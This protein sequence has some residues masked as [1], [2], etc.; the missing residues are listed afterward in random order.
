MKPLK[1]EVLFGSRDN[2]SP[3]LKLI[4]GS[5]NA[6]ANA[7]KNARDEVKRLN[8]QQKQVDGFVRQKKATEDSAKALKDVQER[9]KSLRQEMTTNPSDK[10]SKDFD[11]A[12]KEAKKLKDAHSQN[13][14]KLQE[15]RNELKQTGVSTSN[16]ADHQSELSR[17]ITTANASIDNQKKKLDSLNRIQKSHSNISGNV[18]TAALYGAGMTAT[19][20]AAL[21]QMRKPIDESKRVDVEENRIASLGF[22]KKATDEAVQYAKAMKTFGTSTLDNLTLVRDGVTAFGDV[23]HAQWVAPTLAK[24]KFAN[25]AMYGDHGV[26][27]EKKFMDMLKVIEMRNGLKSKESFQEQA[28]IIQQVI[29]ATGGRVQAE[30]WLNVIKTGGIAAKGMDNKAFYYKM[31]PLVQEMGGH[32]VGTSMMSAYQNL[33]QGRTTQ[34]AA[35]NLDK[36][37]LIGDYSKV[38]HNKTGDLSYLDIGAIKGAD[39][40]KKDQFAW[41][42][43]VLVPALNAKGITKESDVIDAIGSIFSNRTASNLFAQMYMQRDQIHKNAKLNEGAFNIDQL[44]TQAQGTTSGKELE[45]RAKLHDAY[46]QFG[47]TILPIYTQALIMA[48]NA[49]QGFTGW[50]QQNPTLAKALGTGLLLIA[51]GLVAIGGLLLI[52]SPLILSMLS[53]RLMMVTLGVQGSALSFVFK[54]LTS[55]FKALGSSVMWLGRMLFAAGQLMRA[56][57][58]ILAVTLLA[59]AAY[60]IYQN[61]A[62]I[63]SFFMDLWTGVKNAFNTGVSFIKGII[64]SVDQVFA[65]NPLLNLLFPLI[66]IPR[67]IIANWSG[68]TGFFSSVW[69][70]ITTG[71]ANVWNSIV[72]YLGPIG[73]WFA[74]KWENI[75]LVTSVV[76]SGIKSV[77]TT[78]WDNLISAITNSPLFQRIVDGWTKIFDYLGSLKN[79]ML[80]IGKNIIDGLVNGIQSGFD[81]LKTIWAKINSYMPDFM[82]TKMDIHSPSR[83]MAE[84]GGHVIGG[85]GMGLT[86]AF[87]ELKNKYNQVLNLFSNKA[88]SPVLEQVDIAAPVLSKIQTQAT[89]NTAPSRQT[90]LAV[91]GDTYTIHIHAAPGQVVQDIERQIENVVMRLQRDK[92]ARLRT[93]MADQE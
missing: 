38:K 73:D 33:Y 21:Y 6:A 79:K 82:R 20:A 30:E 68:I 36:F 24:M 69:T 10:I 32:R 35:A 59:T 15:L 81:S 70:S 78:A 62:P 65:D 12:T 7:L 58:I 23:H 16:L 91:A 51:G 42:E 1:L 74:A 77:V 34:R 50:M 71:V 28:N 14:A 13:Q 26:E 18:R 27:N 25:E 54:M 45:A 66:G 89:P 22:G 86:Q 3:A 48:S 39:L 31:E 92:L 67:L 55:P 8:E 87:P 93:Y 37:G 56:N 41:M 29:T 2:L 76:W 57:P 83:V 80:S 84:L 64:Q 11:K 88:Q 4:I 5:S 75:K 60:F 46:L 90:S 63:K 49:M 40:F 17:K 53:L 52:F 44:N 85:I 43:K 61:W 19:G 9:I 72:S 47:Q